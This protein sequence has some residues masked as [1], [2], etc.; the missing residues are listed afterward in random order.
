MNFGEHLCAFIW[1]IYLGLKLLGHRK[2]TSG[3]SKHCHKFPE[4]FCQ[5]ILS[6]VMEEDS[7]YFTS[8]MTI[9]I[10]HLVVVQ[11]SLIAILI[12]IHLMSNKVELLFIFHCH[13]VSLLYENLSQVFWHFLKLI[14]LFLRH[15]EFLYIYLIWVLCWRYIL[16]LGSVVAFSVSS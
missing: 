15:F 5:F 3:F 6:P 11:Q 12:C 14:C 1:G 8:W 16:C 7:V 2:F 4:G 10:F 9:V 13:V